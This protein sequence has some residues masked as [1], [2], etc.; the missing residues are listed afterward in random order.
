MRSSSASPPAGRRRLAAV[1]V[2][3][4]VAVAVDGEQHLGLDLR[5]AVDTLAGR[6]RASSGPDRAEAGGGEERDH[7]LGDVRQVGHDAVAALDA[8]RAQAGGDARRP[9]RA[10]RPRSARRARASRRRAGSPS[11]RRPAGEDVLG[12]VELAPANH[13]APGISRLPSTALEAPRPAR[14]RTPRSSP[15]RP[16]GRRPTSAT[17]RRSPLSGAHAPPQASA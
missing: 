15:R 9:G 2:L 14:R 5:E 11:R 12:V 10:A 7:R 6:S 17:A 8:E 3:A 4:A 13:S 16:R 1:E